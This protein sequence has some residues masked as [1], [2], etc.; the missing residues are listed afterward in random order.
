MGNGTALVVAA[1]ASLVKRVVVS[2]GLP[3][4]SRLAVAR[5]HQLEVQQATS[6]HHFHQQTGES[7]QTGY[8]ARRHVNRYALPSLVVP[9]DEL[10]HFFAQMQEVVGL[11]SHQ[12]YDVLAAVAASVFIGYVLQN[13]A[14]DVLDW[15]FTTLP[16]GSTHPSSTRIASRWFIASK[17]SRSD[18]PPTVMPSI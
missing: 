17:C 2:Q 11:C 5:L 12:R 4:G 16:F 3:C 13:Q 9:S 1:H 7:S 10:L 15:P 18:L 8:A 14:V 6:M